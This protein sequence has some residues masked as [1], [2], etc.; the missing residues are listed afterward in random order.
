MTTLKAQTKKVDIATQKHL[1]QRQSANKYKK[2]YAEIIKL[3]IG[4]K[5]EAARIKGELDLIKSMKN[6]YVEVFGEPMSNEEY[7]DVLVEVG[8]TVKLDAEKV[9]KAFPDWIKRFGK[10]Q[11][12]YT[13]IQTKL[14]NQTIKSL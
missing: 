9:K 13:Y 6:D 4:L 8:D 7:H 3:E 14:T 12:G 2:E 10:K 5:S 11:S 1:T